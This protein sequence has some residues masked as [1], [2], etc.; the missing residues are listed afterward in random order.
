MFI[1]YPFNKPDRINIST[2]IST[3]TGDIC[4]TTPTLK[5]KWGRD[6]N[7][8][9]EKLPTTTMVV[10]LLGVVERPGVRPDLKLTEQRGITLLLARPDLKLEQAKCVGVSAYTSDLPT[11]I[12]PKRM[13]A[14]YGVFN[15][16][17]DIGA[18]C[19]YVGLP[20]S[21]TFDITATD[22]PIDVIVKVAFQDNT[23]AEQ[24]ITIPY[25]GHLDQPVIT[26]PL[27]APK[28]GENFA[29]QFKDVG[30]DIYNLRIAYCHPY[31]NN[32][33]NPCL[34]PLKINLQ[35]VDGKMTI[36]DGGGSIIGLT[37]ALKNG[38][39]I[40]KSQMTMFSKEK[41]DKIKYN[42]DASKSGKTKD[43]ISTGVESTYSLSL[44]LK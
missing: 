34:F 8:D 26:A 33:I 18:S 39:V 14:D 5:D 40:L 13:V 4:H 28:N 9:I 31:E 24:K 15:K 35:R 7:F 43:G 23:Y 16:K 1:V 32:G 38:T 2:V 30:A 22:K 20:H 19:D 25:G 44:P 6:P 17:R 41:D 29:L 10:K 21:C 27:T 11:A 12:Q 37:V 42:I 3:F 36:S